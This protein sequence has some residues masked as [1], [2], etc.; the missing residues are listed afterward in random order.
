MFY[1]NLYGKK[2]WIYVY[3]QLIHF[4]VRRQYNIVNQLYPNRNKKKGTEEWKIVL[5]QE[6]IFYYTKC[7]L[8]Q[9]IVFTILLKGNSGWNSTIRTFI[10][11]FQTYNL[12]I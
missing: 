11:I 3:V 10:L 8:K 7:I 2:E 1:N 6:L 4:A 5:K 9:K 12:L